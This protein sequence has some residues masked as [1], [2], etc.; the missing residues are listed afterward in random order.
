[1][2]GY[3]T[4]DQYEIVLRSVPIFCVDLVIIENNFVLLIKRN[5][6]PMKGKYFTPGGRVYKNETIDDAIKRKGKEELGLDLEKIKQ[7]AMYEFLF[8]NSQVDNTSL[9]G[10]GCFY[11][12]R[13]VKKDFEIKLDEYAS[14]YKWEHIFSL[15]LHPVLKELFEGKKEIYYKE[16]MI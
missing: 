9:H 12:C 16:E 5:N 11:L 7:I 1:M 4:N 8:K 15:Y 13:P 10:I 3:L 14:D 6:N 2:E